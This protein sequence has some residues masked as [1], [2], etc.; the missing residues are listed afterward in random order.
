MGPSDAYVA[1]GSDDGRVLLFEAASGALVAVLDAD[2][3]VANCIAPHPALPLL[4][5]GGIGSSVKLWSPP[6]AAPAAGGEGSA[7]RLEDVA[8]ANQDR[9]RAGE[10]LVVGCWWRRLPLGAK[11]PCL[12][13]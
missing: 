10:L 3:D 4:A 9:M 12:R 2:A 8:R 13:T 6:A 1:A 7:A 11:V 5:T